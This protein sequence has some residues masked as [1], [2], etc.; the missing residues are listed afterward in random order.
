MP[1]VRLRRLGGVRLATTILDSPALVQA[2]RELEPAALGRL[3][4]TVGLESAGDLVALATTRQLAAVFDEDLW[5]LRQDESVERFDAAR[6][7][8]WL[9]VMLEAGED[10]VVAR[11]CELPVDFVTLAIHTLVL[12]VDVDRLGVE[13]A[14]AGEDVDYIE[15]ALDGCLCEEWEE[16]RW[17]AR[18][19][20]N[21]DAVVSAL[22]ALDRDHH[23]VLRGIVER[24]AAMTAEY[25]ADNG[26][27]YEVLTAAET[28]EADVA[29]ER[30][31][32][33]AARG[34]VSPAD[35]RSF[36]ELARREPSRGRD[37][38]TRA[39]FRE[40][41]RDPKSAQPPLSTPSPGVVELT[42]VLE[43]A[44]VT[45]QAEPAA[46]RALGGN[47]AEADDLFGLLVTLRSALAELAHERPTVHAERVEELLYVSNVL[48]AA[49]RGRSRQLRPPE[50]LDAA[51]AV[52]A[53]G[54]ELALR[55]P[56][57]KKRA[58]AALPLVRDTPLER[59]FSA[60][61]RALSATTPPRPDDRALFAQLQAMLDPG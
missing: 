58:G 28:L 18:D 14:D 27:L 55:A 15:K 1:D 49:S 16:Y 43:A 2:V 11:L 21:W 40:L 12:V 41:A 48:V 47:V 36:L 52:V 29:A 10:A 26:G 24:C 33:R 38:I 35:A 42:R 37:P 60:G 25:I 56:A 23:D 13:L 6:F 57:V 61:F 7:G 46:P 50:A 5:S 45:T 3:V 34:F 20:S 59:L 44:G 32:R 22:L 39:Y 31:D 17:I 54:L 51:L 4:E 9:S 30:E 19:A 8:L 53:Y